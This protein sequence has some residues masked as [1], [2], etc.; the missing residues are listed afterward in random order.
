MLR[1]LLE[2]IKEWMED[3]LVSFQAT[4]LGY[5]T[6]EM[7]GAK[8]DGTSDDTEAFTRAFANSKNVKCM[9]NKKYYFAST[10]DCSQL[11][12]GTLDI[13]DAI[14]LN[15]HIKIAIK[16]VYKSSLGASAPSKPFTIKNG[17][18]GD[19]NVKPTGWKTPVIQSGTKLAITDIYLANTPYLVALTNSYL[20]G[21]IFKNILLSMKSELW[22]NTTFDLDAINFIKQDGTFVRFNQNDIISTPINESKR[23]FAGDCWTVE[24]VN[25]FRQI[26]NSDYAFCHFYCN[27]QLL[28]EKC[29]QSHFVIGRYSQATFT[30]C[31]FEVAA[32]T[33]IYNLVDSTTHQDSMGNKVVTFRNCYFYNNYQIET[34]KEVD[35]YNCYF[36]V[37]SMRNDPTISLAQSFKNRDY[38][39]MKCRLHDCT[40]GNMLVI[41]TDKLLLYKKLPKRTRT[42]RTQVAMTTAIASTRT[43]EKDTAG[44][45]NTYPLAGEYQYTGYLFTTGANIAHEKHEWSRTLADTVVK[46]DPNANIQGF[47]GGCRFEVYRTLPNGT[48][49][50]ARFYADPFDRDSSDSAVFNL[51]DKGDYLNVFNTYGNNSGYNVNIPIPWI[52]VASI[53]NYDVNNKVYEKNGVLVT[54]D[55]STI[56]ELPQKGQYA[57]ISDAYALTDIDFTTLLGVK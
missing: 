15:F 25:E 10:V 52:N 53:P 5:V 31:H 41:D 18:I 28:I 38:Y 21:M 45:N 47:N 32:V 26:A 34:D 24:G 17:R 40:I 8:G 33:E 1:L 29:I 57:Q 9:P 27:T 30:S 43:L 11:S 37:A 54:T 19:Y 50:R 44:N 46:D 3:E 51:R 12:E 23:S 55:N 42:N 36:R 56:G 48:I 2:T 16:D 49:Q 14:L 6:P 39:D 20:D 35:Y 22:T 13:N 4:R 7:F